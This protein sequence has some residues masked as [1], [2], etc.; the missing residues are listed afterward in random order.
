M[1]TDASTDLVMFEST[2]TD[3]NDAGPDLVLYRS[4]D[5]PG[6][7]VQLGA[8]YFRGRNN[9][10][11]DVDYARIEAEVESGFA[12]S[13]NGTLRIGT[14]SDGT[15]YDSIKIDG[16][17]SRPVT[18]IYGRMIVAYDGANNSRITFE[19]P[20]GATDSYIQESGYDLKFNG[21]QRLQFNAPDK[22][23]FTTDLTI[24][25]A[26]HNTINVHLG[27]DATDSATF[28]YDSTATY[29]FKVNSDTLTAIMVDSSQD[30]VGIGAAPSSG[31]A[32]LQV[33]ADC[34]HY[35]HVDALYTANHDVSVQ[36]AHGFVLQ[37]KT[38]SGTGV[39][40][41]PAAEAGMNLI[42]VNTGAGMNFTVDT[43]DT[44][45]GV[46]DGSLTSAITTT[47]AGVRLIC[48]ATNTW[49]AY[50]LN[51]LATI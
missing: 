36:Q 3:G 5:S 26:D 20:T 41:L 39:F 13:E 40:N 15:M 4:K 37:M 32:Q 18:S 43:G 19:D 46:T 6:D 8:M 1:G 12:G 47:A 9:T 29:D 50:P 27:N 30:N 45:N 28:N 51:P 25:T 24:Y 17:A 7:A 16:T 22:A 44:L 49:V 23:M 34:T 21:N 33:D 48:I 14:V 10:P 2:D 35:Y 31:D 38:G 11:A 42:C